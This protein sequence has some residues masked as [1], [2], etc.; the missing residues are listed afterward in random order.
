ANE[1][2]V[3]I[4]EGNQQAT[5]DRFGF[6]NKSYSFGYKRFALLYEKGVCEHLLKKMAVE[7]IGPDGVEV[8]EITRK[9]VKSR[10]G[11]T[12][13]IKSSDAETNADAI[14]KRNKLTYL[15]NSSGQYAQILN[16]KKMFEIGATIAGFSID[17]IKEM[18]DVEAWGNAD[19]MSEAS[20][21]MEDLMDLRESVERNAGKPGIPWDQA[22]KEIFTDTAHK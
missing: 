4:Y 13:V 21:D 8:E 15:T 11:Y 10:Y 3:G 19:L 7:M 12:Y 2:K 18:L 6:L 5:G 1:D 22:K 16:P 17:E 14:D 9:D 20:R